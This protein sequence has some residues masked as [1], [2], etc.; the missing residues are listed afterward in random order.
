MGS[1]LPPKNKSCHLLDQLPQEEQARMM[2]TA[3]F[4]PY[5]SLVLNNSE[6]F[7][8]GYKPLYARLIPGFK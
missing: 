6:K 4:N 2:A 7:N 8:K 3:R 1:A 5:A